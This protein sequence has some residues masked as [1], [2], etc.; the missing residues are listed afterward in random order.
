MLDVGG[1]V[2]A[3]VDD[4]VLRG[5]VGSAVIG[6]GRSVTI[7]AI[8]PSPPPEPQAASRPTATTAAAA[9]PILLIVDSF[10]RGRR[11]RT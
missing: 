9:H 8:G 11:R 5:V 7:V 3:G 10:A 2:E 6:V 1:V 4:G